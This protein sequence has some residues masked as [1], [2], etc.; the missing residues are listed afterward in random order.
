[1][2]IPAILRNITKALLLS[3]ALLLPAQHLNASVVLTNLAFAEFNHTISNGNSIQSIS[4]SNAWGRGVS[5][6]VGSSDLLLE[7]VSLVLRA[8]SGSPTPL[9]ILYSNVEG[10]NTI[11]SEVI[12]TFT[13]PAD[14]ITST[15]QTYT[16]TPSGS[17]T[18]Q[19]DTQYWLTVQAAAGSTELRWAASTSE[20]VTS[21]G[22]ITYTALR[23]GQNNN[24]GSW[25]T[26]V[27]NPNAFSI[28]ATAVPEPSAYALLFGGMAIGVTCLR[29]RRRS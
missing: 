23:G 25:G 18:L 24:P 12:A 10:A 27:G 26:P 19:A 8:V 29:R 1:M 16:F 3:P 14:S 2:N 11:G 15:F 20:T 28:S 17:V 13:N 9:I 7:S 4:A 5:F 21:D 6:T 22:S